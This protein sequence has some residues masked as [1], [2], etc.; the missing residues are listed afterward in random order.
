MEPVYS[1]DQIK[2][3]WKEYQEAKVL[4]VLIAG[5]WKLR[6]L[7]AAGGNIEATKAEVVKLRDHVSFPKFLEKV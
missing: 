5:K 1:L 4:R 2:D 3:A 6:P 7:T